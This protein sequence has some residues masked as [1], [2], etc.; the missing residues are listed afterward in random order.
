MAPSM[1]FFL[2]GASMNLKPFA[3]AA[4]LALILHAGAA[5]ASPLMDLRADDLLAMAPE[6]RKALTLNANQQLLWQQSEQRT[7][8][9]L[10][11]R[12]G[13]RERLQAQAAALAKNPGAELRE[14][15]T[16]ADA[17]AQASAQEDQALR[18]QWLLLNDALDD[19]QRAVVLRFLADQLERVR[20]AAP[21][22][23]EGGG[24]REGGGHGGP[25]GPG[26]RGR[27]GGAGGMGSNQGGASIGF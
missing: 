22:R 12:Q 15:G 25:G 20:D 24:A 26:G 2:P 13:R 11:E 10:R 27:P 16:A 9:L 23:G 17:E 21:P 14:L 7:R 5:A 6:L 8:A 4:A 19:R 18:A 3:R 1:G